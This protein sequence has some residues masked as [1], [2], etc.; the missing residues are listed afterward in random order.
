MFLQEFLEAVKI[1]TYDWGYGADYAP[2]LPNTNA[3]QA[4]GYSDDFGWLRDYTRSIVSPVVWQ[5]VRNRVQPDYAAAYAMLKPYDGQPK[6]WTDVAADPMGLLPRLSAGDIAA[7]IGA[8]QLQI[9]ENGPSV[10]LKPEGGTYRTPM[11]SSMDL[12]DA[13]LNNQLNLEREA[14]ARIGYADRDLLLIRYDLADFI[15]PNLGDHP[16]GGALPANVLGIL[17]V[18]ERPLVVVDTKLSNDTLAEA[19]LIGA[20]VQCAHSWRGRSRRADC[21]SLRFR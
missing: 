2:V 5:R 7:K 6:R 19:N 18:G 15:I 13:M 14:M 20:G 12:R 11:K 16:D 21:D 9:Q 3:A 4:N 8:T 1:S 10:L 17:T